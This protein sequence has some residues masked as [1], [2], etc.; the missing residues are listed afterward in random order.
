MDILID[1][2]KNITLTKCLLCDNTIT[3][4]LKFCESCNN[5]YMDFMDKQKCITCGVI[6]IV[7]NLDDRECVSCGKMY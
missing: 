6:F 5:N 4:N 2:V 3:N 7:D 1:K